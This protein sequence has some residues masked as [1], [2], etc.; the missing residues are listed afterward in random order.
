[1]NLCC[2]ERLEQILNAPIDADAGKKGDQS[3][4]DQKDPRFTKKQT[5]IEDISQFFKPLDVNTKSNEKCGH[6]R[7]RDEIE[8]NEPKPF[9]PGALP[10]KGKEK[11]ETEEKEGCKGQ[12]NKDHPHSEDRMDWIDTVDH[13]EFAYIPGG[14][15]KDKTGKEPVG[16]IFGIAGE[17]DETEGEV[18]RKSKSSRECQDIHW[19]TFAVHPSKEPVQTRHSSF[20]SLRTNGRSKSSGRWFDRLTMTGHPELVEG[21]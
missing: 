3:K 14:E 18:H 19:F 2:P 21:S 4:K 15:G 20:E 13:D 9:C 7:Y 12:S 1:V 10:F 16:H 5:I 17:H 8:E 11:R 6:N